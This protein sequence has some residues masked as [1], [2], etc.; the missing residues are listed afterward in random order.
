MVLSG[1]K[2]VTYTS[3]LIN[4]NTGGGSK[5]AGLTPTVAKSSWATVAITSSGDG[6]RSLVNLKKNRFKVSAN[7]TLGVGWTNIHG[8]R[9]Y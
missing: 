9:I 4:Q 8:S 3:S 2:K 5:K 1:S 7:M 6:N